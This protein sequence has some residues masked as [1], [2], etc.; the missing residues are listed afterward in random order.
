MDRTG[1]PK[2]DRWQLLLAL[3]AAPHPERGTHPFA[4]IGKSAGHHEQ[5]DRQ[6]DPSLPSRTVMDYIPRQDVIE[7][8]VGMEDEPAAG[9]GCSLLLL[10]RQLPS[11]GYSRSCRGSGKPVKAVR[12]FNCSW[13][14]SENEVGACITP[15]RPARAVRPGAGTRVNIC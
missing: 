14:C 3:T 11:P 7:D 12:E 15:G 1:R 2:L 6:E 8:G 10:P 4:G 13:P 5:H 9:G